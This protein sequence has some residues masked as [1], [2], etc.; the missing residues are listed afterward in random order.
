MKDLFR[1][2]EPV[3]PES[4]WMDLA[5]IKLCLCAVGILLG[6]QIPPKHRK[7]AALGEGGICGHLPPADG[8]FFRPC[9]AGEAEKV[10]MSRTNQQEEAFLLLVRFWRG[11]RMLVGENTQEVKCWYINF[12][13]IDNIYFKKSVKYG[14][15]SLQMRESGRLWRSHGQGEGCRAFPL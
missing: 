3:Y 14:K 2:A 10:R 4:D 11:F 5:R 13:E 1:L 9:P 12:A 6:M 15:L 7:A 8:L